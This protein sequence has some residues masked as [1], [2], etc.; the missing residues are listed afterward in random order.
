MR[1]ADEAQRSRG[2]TR[3]DHEE[4]QAVCDAH[5]YPELVRLEVERRHRL[6]QTAQGD[7]RGRDGLGL[8]LGSGL[9]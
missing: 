6:L 1:R 4:A 3:E 5:P 2:G 9:C 8:G 7:C